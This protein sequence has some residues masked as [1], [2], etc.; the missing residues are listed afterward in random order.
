M[1]NLG[2]LLL[3][4][5]AVTTLFGESQK[6]ALVNIL[7]A[8]LESSQISRAEYVAYRL[9]SLTNHPDLPQKY[10][11]Y[12]P[13]FSRMG[14][15]LKMEA[16]IL[17]DQETGLNKQL[18]QSVLMRPVDLPLSQTS[19]SG[20]FKL[21][22]TEE[23]YDAAADTFVTLCAQAYDDVYDLIVNQLG[24]PAPP[25]D[26]LAAPEYDV[27][28]YNVSGYGMTTAESAAPSA[29][30]PYG[31]T[32]FIEM[33]NNFERTYT[34]GI[35]GMLV[36]AAHEFFHV[37]Q[38]G[39]R[40][41]TIRQIPSAWLYEGMATWMEDFAYDEINDYLQYLPNYVGNLDKSFNTFNGIHEYGSCIFYHMLEKKYG[42]DIL[43]RIW[44][45]FAEPEV[46]D[47]LEN[48]LQSVNSSLALEFADHMLWNYFTGERAFPQLYYPEG[49]LY[50]LVDVASEYEIEQTLGF[51]DFLP[52]M[53]ADYV[54]IRPK[55]L[56]Q[57]FIDPTMESP[58]D[59]MV[60]TIQQPVIGEPSASVM[61]AAGNVILP[62]VNPADDIVIVP[63]NVKIPK[64]GMADQ[65]YEFTLNLGEI[66]DL[67][68]GIQSIAPN[69]FQPS[70]HHHGVSTVVRL[71]EK[72]NK[73]TWS[74]LNE[75]GAQVRHETLVLDSK[76]SGDFELI[77]DGKNSNGD[78]AA[79]GLY[80]IY[81]DAGQDIE[82]G[83]IALIR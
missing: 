43:K 30:Y 21:H 14:T 69:P 51:W 48:A 11:S 49:E 35:D 31:Y 16:R 74:I 50:P 40:S 26:D 57:L 4:L 29:D 66:M 77:W 6:S 44:Q 42:V 28:L 59:W 53:S 55:L 60:G 10:Q 36:T 63:I 19:P 81:I 25:I 45:E 23:G 65:E 76:R 3:V 61:A 47:A 17:L 78:D 32:S 22:Y 64:N 2:T 5:I 41:Y 7:D 68:P 71:S 13:D 37:V 62:E 75:L 38:V 72:T 9:M 79:S 52:Q 80:I 33:N 20:L 24:Y 82:P 1:K 56:G 54:L 15:S 46:W 39:M 12:A 70:I 73:I 58:A 18:L 27:Y 83:K 67:D 34:K 8:E